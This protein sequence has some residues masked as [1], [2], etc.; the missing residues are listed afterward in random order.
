MKENDFPQHLIRSELEPINAYQ[1]GKP[2]REIQR[3]YDLD[4]MPVKLASNENPFSPPEFLEEV[5]REEFEKLNRYPDGGCFY[6]RQALAEEYDWP[7]EAIVLGA[8]SDEVLDCLAK[9]TLGPGKE[10]LTANPAFLMYKIDAQMMGATTIE[11]PVDDNFHIDLE[12]MLENITDSTRW[13]CLANPNNPTSRYIT[14][15]ELEDFLDQVPAHCLVIID[16]AYFELMDQPDYPDG[17]QLLKSRS[18]DDPHL[19]VLRT[20]SKA[21]GLAGL[22]VG[23]GL[24]DPGLA[25]QLNKVRPPFNLTRPS[26]AV[27]CRAL[28]NNHYLEEV[29]RVLTAE[30]EKLVEELKGR[31]FNV[32]PPAANFML[33][34]VP[35]GQQAEAVC[36]E[37][38]KEGV[39]V[40]SMA[41]YGLENHFRLSVGRPEENNL[42][43][44]KLD[45]ISE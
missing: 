5:Y 7:E 2:R 14:E 11:V 18:E 45:K 36:E 38:L 26:Q 6:L 8:G 33:V 9:T 15:E 21:Y 42:F 32:V 27:A 20:F 39:I 3:E 34:E 1:P 16:E 37:L 41:P 10:V 13:I 23:Y 44:R 24:M 43:L 22:R 35:G 31:G 28:E 17:L 30:R 4:R 19:V 29:R 40:R 12:G 25:D